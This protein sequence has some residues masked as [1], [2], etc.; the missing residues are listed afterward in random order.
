[1]AF[2]ILESRGHLEHVPGTAQLND[3]LPENTAHLK[4]GKG[5]DADIVLI[6]QPSHDPND[7]LNWPIWQRDFILLL[8]AFVNLIC[9]GG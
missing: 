8:F 5:K 9:V 7:P 2:G 1:M 4:K 3:V 6:P